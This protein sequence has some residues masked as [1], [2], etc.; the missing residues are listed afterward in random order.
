MPSLEVIELGRVVYWRRD[1]PV[2]WIRSLEL[3]FLL[4]CVDV[5]ETEKDIEVQNFY[6]IS[7]GV[8]FC[9]VKLCEVCG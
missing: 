7:I 8:I 9:C 6:V 3:G 2:D 5:C 4:C 1:W